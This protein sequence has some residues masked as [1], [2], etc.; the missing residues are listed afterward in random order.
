M[1]EVDWSGFH[2]DE[3]ESSSK[4]VTWETASE[5]ILRVALRAS[6]GMVDEGAI[7]IGYSFL[8]ENLFIMTILVLIIFY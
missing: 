4:Q 6:S 1:L 2:F 8:G 7:V 5:N 3:C